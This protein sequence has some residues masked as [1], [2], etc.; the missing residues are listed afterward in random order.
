MKTTIDIPDGLI[1]AV[2]K[3]GGGSSKKEA[4]ITALEEY[5]QRRKMRDLVAVLGTCEDFMTQD[6]LRKMRSNR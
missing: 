1:E 3:S 4:V 2:Q 5:L 6:D